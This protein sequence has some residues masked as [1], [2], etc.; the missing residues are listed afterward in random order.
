MAAKNI[1]QRSKLQSQHADDLSQSESGL[2]LL[3]SL[4]ANALVNRKLNH[5]EQNKPEVDNSL[6]AEERQ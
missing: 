6:P 1:L 3:A 2:R 4:I 5:N